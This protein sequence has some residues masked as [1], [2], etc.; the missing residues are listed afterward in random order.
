MLQKYYNNKH[1]YKAYYTHTHTRTHA[2]MHART[3]TAERYIGGNN[4]SVCHLFISFHLLF[5][6]L[7][8][9][10]F[11]ESSFSSVSGTPPDLTLTIQWPEVTSKTAGQWELRLANELGNSTVDF[12]IHVS[13]GISVCLYVRLSVSLC[14]SPPLSLLFQFAVFSEL[15]YACF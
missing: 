14:L 10:L 15:C 1:S 4:S 9:V 8:I 3:H 2:R 7:I 5:A 6:F 12:S 11:Y 13:D